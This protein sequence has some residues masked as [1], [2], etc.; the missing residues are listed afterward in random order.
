MATLIGTAAANSLTGGAGADSISGLAGNDTLTG[1]AGN[2]TILGGDDNDR[3]DGGDGAD[4]LKGGNGSDTILGGAGK[5]VIVGG[6]GNDV[7][8]GGADADTFIFYKSEG[9][10]NAVTGVG[11]NDQIRGFEGAGVT[12]GDLLQ[13]YGFDKTTAF[14]TRVES[15][16]VTN[17]TYYHIGDKDGVAQVLSFTNMGP[18]VPSLKLGLDYAF[19]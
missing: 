9:G 17:L 10:V 7:L 2:D 3:I 13:F 12:G 1:L 15:T 14:V 5:D 6:S 4:Y 8:I 18:S 16:Q 19:Y 11:E